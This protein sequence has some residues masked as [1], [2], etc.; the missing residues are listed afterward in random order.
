MGHVSLVGSF[1]PW[2]LPNSW[3]VGTSRWPNQWEMIPIPFNPLLKW[4]CVICVGVL[5]SVFQ[6]FTHRNP[7]YVRQLICFLLPQTVPSICDEHHRNDELAVRV[8]QLVKS[9]FGRWDRRL[10]PH[11]NP[12][13]VEQQ[14]KAWLILFKKRKNVIK[15]VEILNQNFILVLFTSNTYYI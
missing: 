1:F 8:H 3:L 12:I 9:F 2:F 15:S 10:P 14:A 4:H 11:Q 7:Q 5:C 6:W 13:N